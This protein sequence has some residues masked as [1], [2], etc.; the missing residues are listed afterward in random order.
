MN[1]SSIYRV[2]AGVWCLAAVSGPVSAEALQ[3]NAVAQQKAI[4]DARVLVP[5]TLNWDF[6]ELT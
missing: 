5:D 4:E 1:R 2:L 3:V 6:S